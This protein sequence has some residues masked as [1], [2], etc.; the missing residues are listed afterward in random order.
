MDPEPGDEADGMGE[1]RDP[2]FGR[3]VCVSIVLCI[4][5]ALYVP[6]GPLSPE[7]SGARVART[8]EIACEIAAPASASSGWA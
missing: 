5:W 2:G 4:G 3:L 7:A 6:T 8:G 1:D